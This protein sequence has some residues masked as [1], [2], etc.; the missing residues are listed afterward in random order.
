MFR[1]PKTYVTTQ[2]DMWDLIA[3]TQMGSETYMHLLIEANP[4]YREMVIFPANVALTIPDVPA[5]ATTA[6]NLPP[7]KR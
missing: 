3:F 4:Q 1:L 7:W 5:A 6:T 2:G